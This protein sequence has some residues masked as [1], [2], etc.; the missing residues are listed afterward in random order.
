MKITHLVI[1]S[2]LSLPIINQSNAEMITRDWEIKYNQHI[3]CKSVPDTDQFEISSSISRFAGE[4]YDSDYSTKLNART[5]GLAVT[6]TAP[7]YDGK[8]IQTLVVKLEPDVGEDIKISY[9][10]LLSLDGK[11]FLAFSGK[12]IIESKESAAPCT[13]QILGAVNKPGEIR[14]TT[15]NRMHLAEAIRQAGGFTDDANLSEV[16]I[17][18]PARESNYIVNAADEYPLY[19]L[20]NGDIIRVP[21]ISEPL[22]SE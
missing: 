6:N 22:P 12:T 18:N 1:L 15:H 17:E 2:I 20:H 7:T 13:V 11:E 9:Q 5:D 8:Y 4:T 14:Y 10:H 19:G 16:E 21:P 3:W